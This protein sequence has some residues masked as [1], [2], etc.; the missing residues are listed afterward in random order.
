MKTTQTYYQGRL[1][2]SQ[3]T[4]GEGQP[5]YLQA[6][7]QFLAYHG[8]KIAHI[9]RESDLMAAAVDDGE[10]MHTVGFPDGQN[11]GSDKLCGIYTLGK[12]DLQES[13]QELEWKKF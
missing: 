13:L 3:V 6:E 5:E 2:G 10:M 11:D 9:L 8:K 12:V 4:E 1:G 7:A